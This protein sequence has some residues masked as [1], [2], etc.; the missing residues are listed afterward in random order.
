M[1]VQDRFNR[2]KLIKESSIMSYTK[3]NENI[4]K[5]ILEK[6]NLI[7]DDGPVECDILFNVLDPRAHKDGLLCFSL[8]K[9]NAIKSENKKIRLFYN[10]K[11]SFNNF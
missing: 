8:V 9:L 3:L 7:F 5:F 11:I 2:F 6:I 10:Y 1:N 4:I